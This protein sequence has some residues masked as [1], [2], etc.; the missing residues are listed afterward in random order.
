MTLPA[1][2]RLGA[3]RWT[4]AAMS[5]G[6]GWRF[7][8]P[9]A[10]ADDARTLAG[11]ASTVS[12][13]IAQLGRETLTLPAVAELAA[14]IGRE[15]DHGS[16]VA[17]LRGLPAIDEQPLRLLYLALG[18]HLGSVVETYGR[19]YDVADG[20]ASYRDKPIPVSQ[21]RES[22]GMHTDSSGK[23]VCPRVIGLLCVRQAP[24]GGLSRVV[25]AA[26]VHE[27]LRASDP[28]LLQ[29]LYAPY[30]RDLVT[31]GATRRPET[32]ATN[33]FPV[34]SCEPRLRLRYMRYWIER[35]HTFAGQPLDPL[36][37][38]AFDALD[39]RLEAPENVLPFR[40]GPGEMLFIDNTTTAHDRDAYEDDPAAPRLMVRLW[41]D[42][43]SPSPASGD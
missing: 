26:Q 42:R 8:A 33:R 5:A 1:P 28:E 15:L 30:L 7:D 2:E 40:M 10:L 22:T 17:W 4:A 14:A 34:F 41:L 19:L 38:A 13:P 9:A 12:D 21:T 23:A 27:E 35:G 36:D 11:W 20:G 43:E 6:C 37:I 3:R 18:L 29:R 39:A 25:S 31:P 16:G 24:R 32:V